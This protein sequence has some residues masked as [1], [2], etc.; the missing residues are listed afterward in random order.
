MIRDCKFL[1][2]DKLEK[3]RQVSKRQIIFVMLVEKYDF[4]SPIYIRLRAVMQHGFHKYIV[5][6]STK[7]K[8]GPRLL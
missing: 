4:I 1:S 3:S 7:Y 6:F 5:K 2:F 8:L